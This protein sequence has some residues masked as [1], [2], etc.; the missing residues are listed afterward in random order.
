MVACLVLVLLLV[1]VEGTSGGVAEGNDFASWCYISLVSVVF[2][3]VV[4]CCVC[5]ILSS[6]NA[7]NYIIFFIG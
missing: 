2:I 4:C 7:T 5:C 1:G 6:A 3:A